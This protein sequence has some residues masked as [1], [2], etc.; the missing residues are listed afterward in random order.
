MLAVIG[1]RIN[2]ELVLYYQNTVSSDED[3]F[4]SY[5]DSYV[6]T[7]TGAIAIYFLFKVRVAPRVVFSLAQHRS[8]ELI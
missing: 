4:V 6:S 2:V 8:P 3:P 7:S 1:F 5:R